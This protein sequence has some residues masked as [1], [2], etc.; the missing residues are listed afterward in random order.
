MR[1]LLR[2]HEAHPNSDQ[3][4]VPHKAC[5]AAFDL[6]YRSSLAFCGRMPCVVAPRS[7]VLK[8]E[9]MLPRI[10]HLVPWGPWAPWASMG[11][12]GPLG[13][14]AATLGLQ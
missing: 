6:Y 1:L 10:G 7:L 11:C 9:L 2:H 5:L 8:D 14:L 4:M 13:F 3:Q 12:M